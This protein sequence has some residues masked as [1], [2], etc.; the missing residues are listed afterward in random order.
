MWGLFRAYMYPQRSLLMLF[1]TPC[2]KF[3]ILFQT[4]CVLKPLLGLFSRVPSEPWLGA[5]CKV[6][7]YGTRLAFDR[8]FIRIMTSVWSCL[9]WPGSGTPR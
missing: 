1:Q 6:D 5:V 7:S 2:L 4:Y 3:L 9:A 8:L